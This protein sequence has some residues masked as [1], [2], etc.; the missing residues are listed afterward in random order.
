MGAVLADQT[1]VKDEN[2]DVF[3]QDIENISEVYLGGRPIGAEQDDPGSLGWTT[4][5]LAM[6]AIDKGVYSVE[7]PPG[8]YLVR[9]FVITKKGPDWD[10]DG[11]PGPYT[12]CLP[13]LPIQGINVGNQTVIN[14]V[15]KNPK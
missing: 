13:G 7:V 5:R 3:V 15:L 1:L 10:N 12:C 6:S 9:L 8:N 4:N 11:V 2:F 14:S